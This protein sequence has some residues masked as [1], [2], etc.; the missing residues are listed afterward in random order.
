MS[1]KKV[2]NIV[3][4]I[5]ALNIVDFADLAELV[6]ELFREN[7]LYSES[8]NG[9]RDFQPAPR[10]DPLV[11]TVTGACPIVENSGKYRAKI[12]MIKL[13]KELTGFGLR[14]A[15]EAVDSL[16]G[17][18]PKAFRLRAKTPQ[19][20]NEI[21]CAIDQFGYLAATYDS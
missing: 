8:V 14:E 10:I 15:K 16:E 11:I 21:L 9:L 17:S 13:V 18:T 2:S 4:S 20:R 3:K 7:R 19:H 1:S 6:G 5:V 12:Q